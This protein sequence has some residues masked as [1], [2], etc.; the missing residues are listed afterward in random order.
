MVCFRSISKLVNGE[1]PEVVEAD[2]ESL[3]N[4]DRSHFHPN[5]AAHIIESQG[6]KFFLKGEGVYLEDTDGRKYVDAYSGMGNV[7]L[8]HGH[9]YVIQAIK[10]QLDQLCYVPAF[11]AYGNSPS[12]LLA[13]SLADVS[14]NG[15]NHVQFAN[16]GS[17]ANELSFKL[18]RL[19]HTVRGKTEKIKFIS[20]RGAYHGATYAAMSAG[21]IPSY[22][23]HF[24]P[25]MDGFIF[26]DMPDIYHSTSENVG[27][28]CAVD[29]EQ[30]IC[31][32]GP[33]TIAAFIIEPIMGVAGHLIPPPNYY[34]MVREICD[35]YDVLLIADEVVC[36]VGRTGKFFGLEHW[37]VVPDMMTLAKGI[38]SGY[39]PLGATVISDA[40][41]ESILSVGTDYVFPHGTT[42]SAHPVCCAAG[43]A[44]LEV[45][46]RDNLVQR[47][48]ELGKYML[49]DFESR[50]S[51]NPYVGDIR[52]L[53]LLA[54]IELVEDRE[55][56]RKFASDR[57]IGRK[58]YNS[59]MQGGVIVRTAKDIVSLRP[60]LISTEAEI[61]K[62]VEVVANAINELA[63]SDVTTT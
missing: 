12:A 61:D 16:S 43:L 46:Q 2:L 42:T 10:D 14:P 45:V 35:R 22:Q 5:T 30:T 36:G 4:A 50:L 49:D 20:Q 1:I 38:T 57:A 26:V 52:G 39:Q 41:W 47:S 7:I 37:S 23:Q 3:V 53:G 62:I 56:K 33:E 54:S 9:P 27:A 44:T 48:H 8:G 32:E 25:M 6:A 15:L 60:P 19:H 18:A 11:F 63:T 55:T 21:G 29:L 34:P 59:S 28:D 31:S 24:G 13:Q 40:V 17:E 58:V 51:E